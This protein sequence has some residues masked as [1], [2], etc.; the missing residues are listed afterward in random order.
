M[1]RYSQYEY[2]Y[3]CV[4]YAAFRRHCNDYKGPL[5]YYTDIWLDENLPGEGV[6]SGEA[7]RAG[8]ARVCITPEHEVDL[9]AFDGRVAHQRAQGRGHL[10]QRGLPGPRGA[11]GA[12]RLAGPHLG[13]ARAGRRH[14]RLGGRPERWLR[15]PRTSWSA[16]RTPISTPQLWEGCRNAGRPDADYVRFVE[17]AVR[18]AA[19]R[20]WPGSR[21]AGPSTARLPLG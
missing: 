18:E 1:D 10:R 11:R 13:A 3:A 20:A 21:S 16:P 9:Y 4:P 19:G 17:R 15:A 6:V 7:L 2:L 14:P 5:A 12:H 8:A